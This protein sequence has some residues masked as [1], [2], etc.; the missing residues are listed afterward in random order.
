L[1]D[2]VEAVGGK[3]EVYVDGGFMRGTD[4]VKAVA[5]GARAV[6]I[7][8]LQAFALAAGGQ[9][10]LMN[11]LDILKTEIEIAMGLLGV[12]SLD[13]LNPSYLT[14]TRPVGPSH[15]MSAFPHIPGGR[16]T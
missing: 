14:K 9:Q 7:G 10:A 3:A 1:P 4:I 11:C 12:T 13:Q 5:L 2:I 6:G 8:K 16:L 15:E